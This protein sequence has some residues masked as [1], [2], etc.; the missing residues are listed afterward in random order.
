VPYGLSLG[1]V[2]DG[3]DVQAARDRAEA[4]QRH[5]EAAARRE[6]ESEEAAAIAS[7]WRRRQAT[8][9]P[10]RLTD[11]ERQRRLEAMASDA[12]ALDQERAHR[13]HR[14]RLEEAAREQQGRG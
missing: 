3:D 2:A 7:Q 6:K 14:A 8:Y 13:H 12:G 10:G 1:R 5:L 9:R 4:T 11:E